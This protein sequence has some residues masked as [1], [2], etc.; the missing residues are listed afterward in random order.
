MDHSM[1]PVR[2]MALAHNTLVQVR[3]MLEPVRNTV[4]AAGSMARNRTTSA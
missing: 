3:N 2:S 1:D 4:L